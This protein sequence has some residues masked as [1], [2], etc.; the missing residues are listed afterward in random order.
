LFIE[1]KCTCSVR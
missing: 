1:L